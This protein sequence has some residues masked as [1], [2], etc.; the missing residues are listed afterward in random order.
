MHGARKSKTSVR[1]STTDLVSV[2]DANITPGLSAGSTSNIIA[3][4]RTR[5]GAR[6][7]D[8]RSGQK[9]GVSPIDAS[10]SPS[11]VRKNAQEKKGKRLKTML[12]DRED[13]RKMAAP[14]PTV[15]AAAGTLIYQNSYGDTEAPAEA[16]ASVEEVD[17]MPD[18]NILISRPSKGSKS[19]EPEATQNHNNAMAIADY[20]NNSIAKSGGKAPGKNQSGNDEAVASNQSG[21]DNA[22]A[23]SDYVVASADYHFKTCGSGRSGRT[24]KQPAKKM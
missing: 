14:T 10:L 23:S 22:V 9:G 17:Y 1:G 12:A 5:K 11:K 13:S 18:G 2:N 8:D 19:A 15:A 3:G 20:H 16:L 21:N 24:R 7:N 6:A 4:G